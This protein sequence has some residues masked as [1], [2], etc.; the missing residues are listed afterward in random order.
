[1]IQGH[2]SLITHASHTRTGTL[3]WNG[4]TGWISWQISDGTRPLP[5]CWMPV[6]RR[7]H[8]FARHG[9][10]AVVGTDKGIVTI[11]EFSDVIAMLAN[12]V[13]APFT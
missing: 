4:S 10:T 5:L 12:A 3:V 1:V 7:G 11:L 9:T 2:T 6:E 8:L 13:H